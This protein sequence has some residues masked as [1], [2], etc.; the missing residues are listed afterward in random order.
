MKTMK[1]FA[2]QQHS[3]RQMNEVKG[4]A[5]GCMSGQKRYGCVTTINDLGVGEVAYVCAGS[6]EQA[7]QMAIQLLIGL[8]P[9][10]G[11]VCSNSV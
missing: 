11:V 7:E 8:G 10:Y 5:S 3:K 9:G 4:G 1:D 2:A 6:K